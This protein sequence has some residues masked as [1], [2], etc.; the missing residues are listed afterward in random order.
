LKPWTIRNSTRKYAG[1]ETGDTVYL[2]EFKMAYEGA[3]GKRL[4][5]IGAVFDSATRTLGEWKQGE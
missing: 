3:A 4:I 2:F 1:A 5:K